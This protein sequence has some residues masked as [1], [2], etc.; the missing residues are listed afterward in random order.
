MIGDDPHL[1]FVIGMDREKVAAGI[2]FK[3]KDIAPFL[4]SAVSDA[5]ALSA[6]H[7]SAF[8]YSYLEKFIQVTFRVPRPSEIGIDEFL[9]SISSSEPRAAQAADVKKT[10]QSNREERR[11][12]VEVHARAD[13][14]EVA[15]LVKMVAPVV[16]WNPRRIKQFING[17]RLHAYVASDLGLL[18]VVDSN[19]TADFYPAKDSVRL[20]LEQLGKFI[21]ITITWP[22]LIMDLAAYPATLG[23]IYRSRVK[24]KDS[25][26]EIPI[27]PGTE[28]SKDLPNPVESSL[29]ARW[30]SE[31][32][33]VELLESRV[34]GPD[35]WRYSLEHANLR[36]LL[37]IS[38]REARNPRTSPSFSPRPA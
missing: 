20:T 26:V 17:F 25:N 9:R 28:G 16:D 29:I 33:L 23:G 18:D 35:G 22:D 13:S 2:A 37:N 15:D 1:V 6:R 19:T 7:P 3:Y 27:V 34:S 8:G 10:D 5:D 36:L 12:L 32:L 31:R 21:A 24:S 38:Q 30:S 11:Q 4:R 14:D